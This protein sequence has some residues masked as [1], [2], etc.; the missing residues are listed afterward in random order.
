LVRVT[1]KTISIKLDIFPCGNANTAR[2]V[3]IACSDS[4]ARFK[5]TLS[6]YGL[7][8]FKKAILDIYRQNVR[9]M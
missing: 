9:P 1:E 2:N 6:D 8:K 5:T 3:T 4:G 7:L